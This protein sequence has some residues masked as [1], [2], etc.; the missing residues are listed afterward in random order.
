[1]EPIDTVLGEVTINREMDHEHPTQTFVEERCD[2]YSSQRTD[3]RKSKQYTVQDARGGRMTLAFH[4]GTDPRVNTLNGWL[5]E[6][7][8][9]ICLDRV[10]DHQRGP[11]ACRENAI[12]ATKLEE[13]LLWMARRRGARKARAV[14]GTQTV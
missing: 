9:A 11:F 10:Q 2:D 3:Q 6:D 8:V 1:M 4:E 13:A 14:S 5:L 12:V 7:L